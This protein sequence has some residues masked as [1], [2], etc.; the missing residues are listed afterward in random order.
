MRC[1]TAFALRERVHPMSST[2]AR[3]SAVS[4]AAWGLGFLLA[5]CEVGAVG[6]YGG[7]GGDDD[8]ETAPDAGIDAA[9]ADYSLRVTPTG[10]GGLGAVIELTVDLTS[11]H[12]SGPVTLAATGAPASWTVAITPPSIDLTDGGTGRATIKLTVPPNGDGAPAGQAIDVVGSATPGQRSATSTVT[13]ENVYTLA[14]GTPGAQGQ[15]FGTMAGG[16]LRMKRGAKLRIMNTDAVA[17]RIH[18]DAGVN[19][20]PHQPSSMG[21]GAAYEV[22]LS[23]TGTDQFYCHDHGQGTGQVR[24]TVE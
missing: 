24:L 5:A 3:T 16:Q 1:G 4:F 6:P 22:T 14:I 19:G 10:R 11:S 18:S 9:P 8:V 12:F 23:S 2:I 7:G 21:A 17:H 15:H 13:V 20:F